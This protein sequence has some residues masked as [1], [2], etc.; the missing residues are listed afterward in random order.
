MALKKRLPTLGRVLFKE[1][2]FLIRLALASNAIK[3]WIIRLSLN[4]TTSVVQENFWGLKLELASEDEN[5][6]VT[7]LKAIKNQP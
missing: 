4:K 6:A 3:V 5:F 2:Q 1:D 7:S